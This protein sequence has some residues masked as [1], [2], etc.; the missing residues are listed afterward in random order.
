MNEFF[1]S[2]ISKFVPMHFNRVKSVQ[3]QGV[4]VLPAS[5]RYF[6]FLQLHGDRELAL[7]HV[8]ARISLSYVS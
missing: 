4:Y 5:A 1:H 6:Y 8:T 3:V 2:F 7:P